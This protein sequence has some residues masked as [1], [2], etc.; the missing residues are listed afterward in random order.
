[1]LRLT[2]TESS[3]ITTSRKTSIFTNRNCNFERDLHFTIQEDASITF[4]G[5]GENYGTKIQVY[6]LRLLQSRG[7]QGL[8]TFWQQN[9][10]SAGRL[11]CLDVEHS[12]SFGPPEKP[13]AELSLVRLQDKCDKF[14]YYWAQ[15]WLRLLRARCYLCCRSHIM[16]QTCFKH[17]GP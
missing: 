11:F 15:Y 6:K 9:N 2:C 7:S 17:H 13:L 14:Q 8:G 16:L 4:S 12:N 1:M 10:L 5:S 3:P